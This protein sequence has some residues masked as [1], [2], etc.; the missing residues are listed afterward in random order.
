MRPTQ[1]AASEAGALRGSRRNQRS[2]SPRR[3]GQLRRSPSWSMSG[4][5]ADVRTR[6]ANLTGLQPV[7]RKTTPGFHAHRPGSR[8]HC[9]HASAR[10]GQ[11]DPHAH[12]RSSGAP[13][14]PRRRNDVHRPRGRSGRGG[15]VRRP[16]PR[17]RCSDLL[18]MPRHLACRGD[19]FVE[20]ARG[21]CGARQTAR[22]ESGGTGP[23]GCKPGSQP[24]GPS[25]RVVVDRGE[26]ERFQPT[27]GPWAHVSE[28]IPA[29]DDHRPRPVERRLGLRPE[30]LERDVDGTGRCSSSYSAG[31]GL[32]PAGRPP[33][34]AGESRLDAEPSI[35]LLA[36]REGR[37][38]LVDR[39][40]AFDAR[41]GAV[42]AAG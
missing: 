27:R 24:V 10:G 31:G 25:G 32:R 16:K 1:S 17:R 36:G 19:R 7:P 11:R 34:P 4:I 28:A 33:L 20:R 38:D 18:S 41:L 40:S 13:S 30:R 3:R 23:F 5:P 21:D 42:G 22:A 8:K 9:A 26:A 29:V 14:S 12:A 6:V 2:K 35:R 39:R 37:H 15:L